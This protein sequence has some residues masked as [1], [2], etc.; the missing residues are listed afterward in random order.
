MPRPPIVLAV[1][2][3]LRR[4]ERNDYFLAG[5]TFLG[6][7]VV[8]G[9]LH[10]MPRSTLREYAYPALLLAGSSRVVVEVY[11]L[12]DEATLAAIDELE[13]FDPADEAASQY[14][15]RSVAVIDG[16]VSVA[17]S[18]LYNGPPEEIGE[19]IPDGDWVA[20]QQETAP[21]EG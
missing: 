8:R 13:A 2:G 10:V 9:R 15:R 11:E 14:V 1:Y 4:G 16:P 20:H 17:W 19:A 3:T 12:P 6:R 5:S 18:Y 21:A 7:G